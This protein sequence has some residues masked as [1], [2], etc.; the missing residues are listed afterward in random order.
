MTSNP[1]EPPDFPEMSRGQILIVMAVTAL[2]L[3]VVT[4]IWMYFGAVSLFPCQVTPTAILWGI[5]FAIAISGASALIYELWPQYRESAD[6]YVQMVVK[7]LALPDIIWLG[8][9]PGLS[10]E[11]LFRGVMLP[12]FGRNWEGILISSICFGVLHLSGL[13]QW[14][15]I[16]WATVI[17]GVLGWSAV[18]SGNLLVPIVAHTL[19]NIIS[20]LIWK[21]RHQKTISS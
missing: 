14:P 19:T 1:T 6:Y 17:G 9:L 3:M 2:V 18:W 7:P 10:E 16:I 4:R 15:Y 8:L 13:K 21:Y 11:L 5:G 12:V 20:A